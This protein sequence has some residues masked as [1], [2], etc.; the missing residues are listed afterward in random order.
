VKHAKQNPKQKTK[1]N[2]PSAGKSV[3]LLTREPLAAL[4]HQTEWN[5][6]KKEGG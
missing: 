3:A 6:K 1:K 2:I 4:R 5:E